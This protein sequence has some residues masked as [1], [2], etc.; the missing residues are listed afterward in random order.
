MARVLE[1]VDEAFETRT[2]WLAHEMQFQPGQFIMV[3]LLHIDEKPYAISATAPGRIAVTVRKR[4]SFSAALMEQKPGGIVGLRGPYGRGYSARGRGVIVAGG[5]GLAMLA[6]LKDA[7]PEI[8]VI[9]GAKTGAELLFRSRFADMT[10]CTD[11]GSAGAKAFPTE[12]LAPMLE[13]G[14][15]DTVYTCGPEVM[16]RAVF[17]LCEKHGA[18]CQA[19]LERYMKCGF[20]VCGQCACGDRLVCRDGPV[21][22]SNELREM[23]EFGRFARMKSGRLVTLKEYVNTTGC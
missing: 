20:G 22:P 13:K 10:I 8:A 2:L 6:P 9:H 17:D 14:A 21:F 1:V 15:V 18:E 3:W 4:G 19:G 11:D 12:I 7:H 5:C 23:Q 16:M